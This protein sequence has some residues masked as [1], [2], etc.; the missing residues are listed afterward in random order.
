M[1]L[2]VDWALHPFEMSYTCDPHFSCCGWRVGFSCYHWWLFSLLW[3]LCV[4]HMCF[5]LLCWFSGLCLSWGWR[6]VCFALASEG[7]WLFVLRNLVVWLL[8]SWVGN[9]CCHPYGLVWGRVGAFSL[10]I[11]YFA[12][13]LHFPRT[14]LSHFASHVILACICLIMPI[15]VLGW[16]VMRCE[17][18]C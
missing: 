5:D 10:Y 3:L 7:V 11:V 15:T 13:L 8:P 18:F 16:V 12:F 14:H 17:P 4:G 2:L 9:W 1:W 6:L